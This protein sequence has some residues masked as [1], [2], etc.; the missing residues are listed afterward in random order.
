MKLIIG[1]LTAVSIPLMLLNVFG[2]VI[3]GVWLAILGKWG[4]IIG[5][6]CLMIASTWL[7]GLALMPSWLF[8]MPAAYFAERRKTVLFAFFGALGSA[9]T[10]ALV[11]VWCCSVL[12]VFLN[13]ATASD[14]LPRVLWSYGVAIGPWGYMA[15]KDQGESFA[16]TLSTFLA[17]IA[18]IVVVLLAATVGLTLTESLKIFGAFMAV[19]LLIQIAVGVA[20]QSDQ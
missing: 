15:S 10:L 11:T 2:G 14:F 19:G 6:I 5:G 13:K 18:Y 16:S 8:L 1:I 9:Y 12:F 3:A 20:A 7:I 4:T 17:Q